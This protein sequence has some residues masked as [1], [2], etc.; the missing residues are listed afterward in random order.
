MGIVHSFASTFCTKSVI[1]FFIKGSHT[2]QF[3][4]DGD[5]KFSII[6]CITF[7]KSYFDRI[8]M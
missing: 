1:L 8:L 6:R 4:V 2:P 5:H 7:R 3:Y